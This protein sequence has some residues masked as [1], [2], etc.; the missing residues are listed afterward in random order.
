[1]LFNSSGSAC[2]ISRC[3]VE[4]RGGGVPQTSNGA[5]RPAV[6]VRRLAHS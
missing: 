2:D 6:A 4:T 1:M 3:V 5:N